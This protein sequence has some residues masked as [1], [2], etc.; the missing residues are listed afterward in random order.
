MGGSSEYGPNLDLVKCYAPSGK[1]THLN[2]VYG[3]HGYTALTWAC[4]KGY[5]EIVKCLLAA[6]ADKDKTD[7]YGSTPLIGAA[8][9]GHVETVQLLL[10][11]GADKDKADNIGSTP[12]IY[13][14]DGDHHEIVQLLQQAG[15]QP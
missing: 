14:A 5:L 2:E 11:T 3:L 9:G 13:A 15:L 8:R 7:M 10:S 12:L 6:G 1:L 4:D